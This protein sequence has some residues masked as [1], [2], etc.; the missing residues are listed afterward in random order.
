MDLLNA[1]EALCVEELSAY[2]VKWR[3]R[4]SDE[5]AH[6]PHRLLG[7][8]YPALAASIPGNFPDPDILRLY[9][10]PITSHSLVDYRPNTHAWIPKLP[11]TAKLA[12]LCRDLFG[13]DDIVDRFCTG[14]WDGECIRRLAQVYPIH[15]VWI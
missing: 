8:H 14:V 4:L 15:P 6:D 13:W 5:L 3:S 10:E 7:R 1:A 11:D 9:T 2:L 12:R